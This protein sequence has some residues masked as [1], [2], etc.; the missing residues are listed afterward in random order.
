MSAPVDPVGL[1]TIE[2]AIRNAVLQLTQYRKM[3]PPYLFVFSCSCDE[4]IVFREKLP[5]LSAAPSSRACLD[6]AREDASEMALISEARRKR[7]F[8]KRLAGVEDQLFGSFYPLRQQPLMG[9]TPYRLSERLTEMA[10]RKATGPRQIRQ[11][12]VS[13]QV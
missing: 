2:I 10:A 8:A 6:Q 11:R 5:F 9:R 13:T 4:R 3:W 12:Y 1:S 7:D